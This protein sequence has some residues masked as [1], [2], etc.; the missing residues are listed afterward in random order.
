MTDS[1]DFDVVAASAEFLY[2]H[3]HHFLDARQPTPSSADAVRQLRQQAAQA[4]QAL[5]AASEAL[6]RMHTRLLTL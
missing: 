2:D 4:L 1:D 3:Q 5:F 6:C